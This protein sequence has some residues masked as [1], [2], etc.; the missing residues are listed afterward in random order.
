[1]C[2]YMHMLLE[3]LC[4]VKKHIASHHQEIRNI[5]RV[6]LTLDYRFNEKYKFYTDVS[7]HCISQDQH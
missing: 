5:E 3:M 1:M 2:M 6:I 4:R 7:I